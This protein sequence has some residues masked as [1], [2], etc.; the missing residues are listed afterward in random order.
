MAIGDDILKILIVIRH[1][2]FGRYE[3]YLFYKNIE[4]RMS[5]INKTVKCQSPESDQIPINHPQY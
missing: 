1:D 2:I 4:W 3:L 5:D